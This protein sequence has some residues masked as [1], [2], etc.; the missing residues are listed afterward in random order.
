MRDALN[1]AWS[2]V[3]TFVPKFVAFL[4]ILI[5]GWIIAK[6]IGKGVEA[7]LRRVG[8]DRAVERGGLG[9]AFEG[10]AYDASTLLSKLVYYALLLFVLQL[11]FGVFGPNPVSELLTNV[12]AFL[13]KV[14]VAIIIVV[15]A[16]AIASAVRDLI[17]N[18]L[19]RLSYGRALA[20]IAAVFILGLGVI[21]AL[22]QIGVATTVTTPVLIAVL[23][24][25]AGILIVGVGGGLVRPMQQ[26]WE[27]YLHTA[28]RETGVIRE[29]VAQ[30]PPAGEQLKE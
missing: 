24:T 25:I 10:S 13:P 14:V 26:R 11:A 1:D 18:T 15:V 7:L 22:N 9:R 20:N 12:I 19:A 16:A 3:A 17:S 2:S 28:E 27:R 30:A 5:I 6:F 21:A 29:H 23:A 4:A 8:F